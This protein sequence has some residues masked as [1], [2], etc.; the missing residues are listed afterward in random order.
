MADEQIS[1]KGYD[2]P[3]L[4]A[5]EHTINSGVTLSAPGIDQTTFNGAALNLLVSGPRFVF[6][7]KEIYAVFPPRDSFGE[8]DSVLPHIELEPATLPW[9]RKSGNGDDKTPWLA[10]ILLQEEEWTDVAKVGIANKSWTAYR[11]SV[12][13][14]EEIT[15]NPPEGQKEMP[16]VKILNI[17]KDFLQSIMPTVTDSKWLSHIRVGHDT[18][19]N[20]VERAVL[21][22]NRMPKAGAR[23]AV[24]L[25]S[26]EGRLGSR[27]EFDYDKG[28]T[29]GKVPLL[30]IY[31]WEFTCPDDEQFEINDKTLNR[32][33]NVVKQQ[34]EDAIKASKIQRDVLYRGKDSFI[35]KLQACIKLVKDQQKVINACHIQTE[36]FKGLM[37]SLDMRWIHIPK[38]AGI[39]GEAGTFFDIGSVPLAHGLRQGGKTVSWYRGPLM[40]DKALSQDME[41]KLLDNPPLRSA[42]HLLLYNE[43]TGMLDITYAAAWQLGRL[44]S[45]S[46]PRISQQIAQWKTSHAREAALAEQNLAFSHIP[47]TDA[48]FVHQQN[49]ALEE[50]LNT[51]FT[52]LHLFKGVPFHYLVPH[53]HYLPD[54][55]MRFFYVDPLWMDCLLDGAFSIGRVTQYD[56]EREKNAENHLLKKIQEER[57]VL[58]GILL[59]S[60]LVSGWP[61]LMVEAFKEGDNNPLNALRFDRLGPN[62]LMVIF[63]GSIDTLTLHLPPG[64]APFWI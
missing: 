63:G 64:V 35:G 20:E 62:V 44:L 37:D 28:L 5:G 52:D 33:D 61:S 12:N 32:L 38:P 11:S 15:D 59:R 7:P 13:L 24:H 31:S 34:V 9:F 22:C 17:D 49:T 45:V 27:G 14:K 41:A 53:A 47:F 1:F 39:D 55:S 23:A 36:T 51:Y 3:S 21:V 40:A 42:D 8:F 50:K 6:S 18:Q 29:N 46:D 48:A 57:P 4:N 2:L 10:L 60:D 26:L 30:S 54:E 19:G 58:T 25:V 43:A 56:E 16:P